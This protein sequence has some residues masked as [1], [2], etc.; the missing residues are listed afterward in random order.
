MTDLQSALT[1]SA[2]DVERMMD[3]LLPQPDGVEARL[4]EA[5]RH[6]AFAGG[7][8]LRPFLVMQ[9]ARQF[10][11]DRRFPARVAAAVQFIHAYHLLHDDLP[12]LAA[13]ATRPVR[14]SSPPPLHQHTLDLARDPPQAHATQAPAVPP[15]L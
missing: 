6:S 3:L 11:V 4:Y 10:G 7:K 2:E 12:A 9:A 5:M 15:T 1:E 13:A 14:P 8:R